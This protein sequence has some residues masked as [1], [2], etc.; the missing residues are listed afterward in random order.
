[1]YYFVQEGFRGLYEEKCCG[2]GREEHQG[3]GLLGLLKPEGRQAGVIE[4]NVVKWTE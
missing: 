3:Q 4:G 2:D 1:M